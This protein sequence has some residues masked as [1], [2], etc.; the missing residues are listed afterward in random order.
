MTTILEAITITNHGPAWNAR[1]KM[2]VG[3]LL[4]PLFHHVEM[5]HLKDPLYKMDGHT[6]QSGAIPLHARL[7]AKMQGGFFKGTSTRLI[8]SPL[9]NIRWKSP[10]VHAR[11]Q[12]V[13]LHSCIESSLAVP[14]NLKKNVVGG[15][16]SV[17]L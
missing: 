4:R 17:I 16:I 3:E 13:L 10:P 15:L 14:C 5:A 8:L 11:I 6:V 2:V 1:G 12:A 9:N 7:M